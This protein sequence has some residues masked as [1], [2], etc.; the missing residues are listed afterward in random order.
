[1]GGRQSSALPPSTEGL[2]GYFFNKFV[3]A[4]SLWNGP[5]PIATDR[6]PLNEVWNGRDAAVWPCEPSLPKWYF[7]EHFKT[8]YF[9]VP[10]LDT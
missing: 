5:L 2:R 9:F 6:D 4:K 3:L 8:N 7:S 10:T 1:M